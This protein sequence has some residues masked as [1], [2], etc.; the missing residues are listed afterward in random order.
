MEELNK[1]NYITNHDYL[2]YSRFAQFLRCEASAVAHWRNPSS[3]ST[4]VGS[5]VDSFFSGEL[6]QFKEEHPEIYNSRTGELKS[7]Y[8]QAE[9]IIQRILSDETF[10]YYLS[11][12]KQT[13]MT[14]TIEGVPF[15]IKMDSYK[16]G[17]FI[18]DLKVMK[19]F[20]RVWSDTFGGY[21]TFIEGYDYDIELAIFQEI[22]YQ[23]TG[24]KLPCYLAC[25]T[26]EDPS[27]IGIF[28]LSQDKLDSVLQIVKNNMPRI[29]ALL[30]GKE[31]PHRCNKCSY[32][33]ATK[34][35]M[36]LSSD[37]VGMNGDQLRENGIDCEDTILNK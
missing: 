4:L 25:I 37:Y 23:N 33:R 35:A 13:I 15:K 12:D 9:V 2:S 19:D 14:G 3:V 6:E 21:T 22:V 30:E 5:Y 24:K 17:E 32:C 18:T 16:E 8:K 29:K 34:K 28:Q 1:D 10:M 27:D 31:N 11:G 20:L 36:V 26:K 7:D